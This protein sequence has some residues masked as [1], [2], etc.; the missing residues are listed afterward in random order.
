VEVQVPQLGGSTG[1]NGSP[2]SGGNS[3]GG[4]SSGGQ[5]SAN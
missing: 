2:D 1:S 5:D 3:S 4:N